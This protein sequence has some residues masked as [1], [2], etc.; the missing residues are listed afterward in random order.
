MSRARQA[1]RAFSYV[2][3]PPP[4]RSSIRRA[5][6]FVLETFFRE[7][8]DL[9]REAN[10]DPEPGSIGL[11]GHRRALPQEPPHERERSRQ[12]RMRA[13]S[14]L[15]FSKVYTLAG[16]TISLLAP[17]GLPNV[18]LRIRRRVSTSNRPPSQLLGIVAQG[19]EDVRIFTND[20]VLVNESRI[21]TPLGGGRYRPVVHHRGHRCG[22]PGPSR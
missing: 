2:D 8:R 20:D 7:P 1:S 19:P 6:P 14:L 21:F 15:A 10:T 16:G 12:A 11:R 3:G 9:G 22:P 4:S 5:A 17:G 18:G 13:T